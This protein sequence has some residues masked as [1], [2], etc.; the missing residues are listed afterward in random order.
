MILDTDGNVYKTGLKLD[1][2]PKKI[3]LSEDFS[4]ENI[5]IIACGRK[6]YAVI[7]R[8]NQILTWGNVFKALPDATEDGFGMHY[9]EDIFD[10]G[11]VKQLSMKYSI[12]GAI[13]EHK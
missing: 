12:F 1:Y 8:K 5:D 7:N 10:G 3:N 9:G 13:V 4:S 6:H 11:K 2:T